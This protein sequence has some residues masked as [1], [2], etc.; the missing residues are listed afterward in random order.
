M[1]T[2]LHGMDNG[3][4]GNFRH[5]LNA[6]AMARTA[7]KCEYELDTRSWV[8]FLTTHD[9]SHT[10]GTHVKVAISERPPPPDGGNRVLS[11]P[12]ALHT[13]AGPAH[14]PHT[15]ARSSQST[16]GS[17]RQ[18]S[19]PPNAKPCTVRSKLDQ[20]APRVPCRRR[21]RVEVAPE[22]RKSVTKAQR[23]Q[24][25]ACQQAPSRRSARCDL[26]AR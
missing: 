26:A 8:P 21:Q 10:Y 2:W 4:D 18:R 20:M 19:M 17:R 9:H 23:V 12:R 6:V 25:G 3:Y 1:D 24:N 11:R 13:A 14:A 5:P 22:P 15:H 7:R 16:H